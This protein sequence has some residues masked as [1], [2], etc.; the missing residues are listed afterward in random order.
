MSNYLSLAGLLLS[1]HLILPGSNGFSLEV[2]SQRLNSDTLR[3]NRLA[4]VVVR[5]FRL[6]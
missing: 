5:F 6:R 3:E 4:P 2:N 1:A